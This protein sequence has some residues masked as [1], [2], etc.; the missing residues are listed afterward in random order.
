[1]LGRAFR[2]ATLHGHTFLGVAGQ[3]CRMKEVL[4]GTIMLPDTAQQ[5]A[6]DRGQQVVVAKL[7]A[8]EKGQNDVQPGLRPER[9]GRGHAAVQLDYWG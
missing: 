6:R 3:R 4:P 1:M 2:R 8:V 9:L 5:V 7:I